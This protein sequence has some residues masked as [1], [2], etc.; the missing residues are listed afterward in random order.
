MSEVETLKE[1]I[2]SMSAD[3]RSYLG[4]QRKAIRGFLDYDIAML[5]DMADTLVEQNNDDL[6]IGM[7]GT[8]TRLRIKMQ[9]LL[10]NSNSEV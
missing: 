1:Q 3:K 10:N 6:A 2:V 9:E 8:V 4:Q 5:Q 7:Q